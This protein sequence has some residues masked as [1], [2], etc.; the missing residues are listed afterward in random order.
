MSD[1]PVY[2]GGGF[3]GSIR[4]RMS[5]DLQIRLEAVEAQDQMD[6][7]KAEKDRKRRV[8]QFQERAQQAAIAAALEA[9]QAFHPRMLRG[10]GVGHTPA[11]FIAQAHARMDVEDA[12]AEAQAAADYRRWQR[13]YYAGTSADTSAP[14]AQQLEEGAQTQARTDFYMD[15]KRQREMAVAE[16][17]RLAAKD[18]A[19][20][21]ARTLARVAAAAAATFGREDGGYTEYRQEY[22]L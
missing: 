2:E 10:E 19:R 1:E 15:C 11:E 16:A 8:E 7:A 21:D 3:G 5:E 4:S 18:S 9:G 20:G 22:R 6:A 17:R 14:T 13:E 12:H